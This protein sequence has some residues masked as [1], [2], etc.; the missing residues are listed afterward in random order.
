MSPKGSNYAVAQQAHV[1]ISM[2]AAAA[3]LL[4]GNAA[5]SAYWAA[6]VR[7]RATTLTRADFNRAFPMKSDSMRVRVSQALAQ[8]GL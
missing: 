6:N 5:R 4:S 2:I 1:L 3:H 8:L 7:E